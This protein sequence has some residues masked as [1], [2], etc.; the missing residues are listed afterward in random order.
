MTVL[1]VDTEYGFRGGT[2]C[3]SAF[4]PVVFC[5]VNVETGERHSF[6]GRDP[7]LARFVRD[8]TA[9]LFVSHNLIAEAKYLL[10]LGI[11]P[12]PCWWDTMLAWRYVSN[13]EVV[14]P[15]GLLAA[16]TRLGEP[17][18]HGGAEKTALQERIGRLAFGPN[19]PDDRRAILAYCFE[20]CEGAARLYRR[21]LTHVPAAWMKYST[22]FC[23]ELA[24]MELR[25]VAVD[26]ERYA[27]VLERRGEVVEAVTARANATCPAF[28]NGQLK[29]RRFFA[30][31]AANGVGWPSSLSPRTGRRYLS[32]DRRTFERMKTAHPFVG[33][34]HEANKT[35]KQLND[36]ELTVDFGTGRHYFGNIP[37]GMATGRT[38]F[39][40]FLFSA[41]KWMRWLAVPRSA[42]HYLVSVDFE[43][44][45]VLIGAWLTHDSNMVSGYETKDPHLA[46]AILAGAAPP[47]ATKATHGEVRKKYKCVNLGTNYG[48]SAY[49]IAATTGM[50]FQEA[51][52]LLRQ[53]RRTYSDFWAWTRGYTLRAFRQGLC[54]TAGGWPRKVSPADN[55]RSVANF[56]VQG[57][58]GDLM[59]LATIYLSRHGLQLLATNHDGFLLECHRSEWG[60]LRQAVDSALQQ[61]VDQ[62]LPG[63][64]MRWTVDCYE[65]RYRDPDGKPLWQL[66]DQVLTEGKAEKR[67]I[68]VG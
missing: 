37:F 11:T 54:H 17:Y 27:R 14:Q 33:A 30:W 9:A 4:V 67:T 20:D 35:A 52:A 55:P 36:R 6:W 25:G 48:Q 66:V 31:C 62:V 40:G 43:A 22:E 10:R 15:F 28:V 2:E 3:E 50:H 68:T 24:R 1:S 60:E 16:L 44:E 49:G 65:D 64:P 23:L 26:T 21:L 13:A 51:D 56:P 34:V 58:G 38:A 12:P 18:G 59:R 61:A 32:L 45:E 47:G 41:P 29:G 7:E 39:R 5:A 53:H 19:S 46:F 8:H 57:T 42:E 63:A